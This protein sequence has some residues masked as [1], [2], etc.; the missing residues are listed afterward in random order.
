MDSQIKNWFG[1]GREKK[2]AEAT[3][4]L[5]EQRKALE[6]AI[7]EVVQKQKKKDLANDT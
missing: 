6:D 4:I 5:R 3:Q 1:W 2:V 7:T